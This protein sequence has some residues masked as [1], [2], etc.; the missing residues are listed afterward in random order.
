MTKDVTKDL[1]MSVAK[2]GTLEILFLKNK[3]DVVK[4]AGKC[5]AE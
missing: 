3:Q 1:E 2:D 5:F 4:F